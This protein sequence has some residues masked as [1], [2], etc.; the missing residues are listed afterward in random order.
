MENIL[1]QLGTKENLRSN[2]SELRQLIKE[3]ANKANLL[4]W[5]KDNEGFVF[6]F[7]QEEDAKTRKN[8]ALLLGDLE[9]QNALNALYQAYEREK[10]LF[11]KASYL[12]AMEQLDASEK[13]P[14]LKA[15]LESLLAMEWVVT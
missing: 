1:K 7:L 4:S 11:V 3:D 10:T 14:E 8:T 13:L 9:Y 2:L 15:F 6:S 12:Q 5:V